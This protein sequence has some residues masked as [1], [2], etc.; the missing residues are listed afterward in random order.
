MI[1]GQEPL[2]IILTPVY[3]GEGFLALS[4]ESVLVQ[5]LPEF[6][7]SAGGVR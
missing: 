1:S 2:V 7:V 4:I 6:R 3:N 5:G